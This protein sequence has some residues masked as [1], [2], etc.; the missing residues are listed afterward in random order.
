MSP[1][2][3]SHT[4]CRGK[5]G[6]CFPHEKQGFSSCGLIGMLL[7]FEMDKC[8]NFESIDWIFFH[9]ILGRDYIGPNFVWRFGVQLPTCVWWMS[10]L[11]YTYAYMF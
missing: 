7:T 5:Q 10:M 2:S 8:V 1:A 9:H 11:T 4:L 6:F 3:P